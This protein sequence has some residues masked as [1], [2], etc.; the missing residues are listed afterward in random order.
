MK[1]LL[2]LNEYCGRMGGYVVSNMKL[3]ESFEIGEKER[4][5]ISYHG[6]ANLPMEHD[7]SAL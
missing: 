4:A 1:F 2:D 3:F 7:S 5:E 6:G